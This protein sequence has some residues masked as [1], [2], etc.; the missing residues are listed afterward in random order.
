MIKRR[1]GKLVYY[2]FTLSIFVVGVMPDTF[3]IPL[4]LRPWIFLA[5]IMWIFIF[6]S[7]VFNS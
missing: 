4:V 6:S 5:S 3:N 7:G 2:V 1:L